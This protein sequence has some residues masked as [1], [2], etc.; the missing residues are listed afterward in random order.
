MG[1]VLDH[2]IVPATDQEEAAGFY[3]QILGFEYLGAMGP[4]PAVRVNESLVLDF[5]TSSEFHPMHYAFAMDPAEFQ[6]A[7]QRIKDAGLPYGDGPYSL[8]NMRG[9]GTTTGAKGQ[10][11]AV[12]F[13]DPNGHVLEIKT[14]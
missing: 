3:A 7:F 6:A 12:Y 13:K 10:G 4:F 5:R 14:Y 1:T 9:P 11:K 8:D 2:T